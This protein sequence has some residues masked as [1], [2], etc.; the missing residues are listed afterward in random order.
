MAT[1]VWCSRDVNGRGPPFLADPRGAYAGRGN[2]GHTRVVVPQHNKRHVSDHRHTLPA[3]QVS[4]LEGCNLGIELW[5]QSQPAA[6]QLLLQS[7]PHS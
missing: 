2:R 5:K 3:Q 1:R 4:S 7:F 6:I